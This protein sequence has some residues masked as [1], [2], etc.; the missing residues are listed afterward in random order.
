MVERASVGIDGFEHTEFSLPE[1]WYEKK[2]HKHKPAPI[3]LTDQEL[4][5]L[6]DLLGDG[7]EHIAQI[8][9]KNQSGHLTLLTKTNQEIQWLKDPNGKFSGVRLRHDPKGPAD[10]RLMMKMFM[11]EGHS[12]ELND[13]EFTGTPAQ[14]KM[15]R[16]AWE[17]ELKKMEPRSQASADL[18]TN[19]PQGPAAKPVS[20]PPIASTLQT[21]L[22]AVVPQEFLRANPAYSPEVQADL[23]EVV[24]D[25]AWYLREE[26]NRDIGAGKLKQGSPD[27]TKRAAESD[28]VNKIETMLSGA[29][30]EVTGTYPSLPEST[31][32]AI[33]RDI[34]PKGED[35]LVIGAKQPDFAYIAQ[36]LGIQSAQ[37]AQR[38]VGPSAQQ[39]P[40]GPPPAFKAPTQQPSQQRGPSLSA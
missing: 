24:T 38:P 19:D 18:S 5:I 6:K 40:Y 10:V 4:A 9:N 8:S 29:K 21:S 17:A 20:G 7:H 23:L 11:A 3:S 37:P 27:H 15:L 25:W 2:L 32:S 13:V 30:D 1:G 34:G 26:L 12:I 22:S 33:K 14:Q 35:P 39:G 28:L 36:K 16:D 31:L